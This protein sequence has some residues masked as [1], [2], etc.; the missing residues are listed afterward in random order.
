M[1]GSLALG[2]FNSWL[3]WPELLAVSQGRVGLVLATQLFT[4]ILLSALY[5]WISRGRSVVGKWIAITL[6]VLGV[7][8]SILAHFQTGMSPIGLIFLGQ[9]I[10]SL[11]ALGLLFSRSARL[12]F[13]GDW[14]YSGVF[15]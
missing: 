1:L 3:R 5:L 2:I 4:L 13:K 12:W 14:E 9:T 6:F 11:I 15:D 7:P 10:A 8:F